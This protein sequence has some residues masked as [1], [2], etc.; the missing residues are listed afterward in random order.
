VLPASGQ[1]ASLG[2]AADGKPTIS[3][4]TGTER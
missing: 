2:P 1:N 3:E 4:P